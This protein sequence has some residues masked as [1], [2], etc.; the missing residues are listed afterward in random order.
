VLHSRVLHERTLDLG[1]FYV[2]RAAGD[3]QQKSK[4]GEGGG[5]R[6]TRGLTDAVLLT[7]SRRQPCKRR[8]ARGLECARVAR[9]SEAP[10]TQACIRISCDIWLL[11]LITCL[12]TNPAQEKIDAEKRSASCGVRV[13]IL[14]VGGSDKSTVDFPERRTTR[15]SS[16][17]RSFPGPV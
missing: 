4:S 7:D 17:R 9:G 11:K 6:Y 10:H 13:R 5:N 1:R 12:L 3:S 16:L 15:S 8:I 14:G 2:C